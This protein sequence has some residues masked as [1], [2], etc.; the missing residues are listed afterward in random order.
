M[1]DVNGETIQMQGVE[2]LILPPK[3]RLNNYMASPDLNCDFVGISSPLVK[4]LLGSHIE[5]WN[6]SIYVNRTN[7]IVGQGV[8][9]WLR[10]RKNSFTPNLLSQNNL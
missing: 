10:R 4:R 5:E 6:R 9:E 2:A 8:K 3:T 7:H 1:V